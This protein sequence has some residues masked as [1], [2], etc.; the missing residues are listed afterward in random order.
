MKQITLLLS[1]LVLA[2]CQERPKPKPIDLGKTTYELGKS[3]RAL[4]DGFKHG[5]NDTTT[6]DSTN[7]INN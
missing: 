7:T 1:I 5:Y 2:S 6:T 4:K 3:Y